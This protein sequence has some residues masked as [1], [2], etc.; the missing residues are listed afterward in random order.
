MENKEHLSATRE[1]CFEKVAEKFKK[2][3]FIS[4][5]TSSFH[6]SLRLKGPK[7]VINQVYSRKIL[8]LA[9]FVILWC[10]NCRSW[11]L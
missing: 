6:G 8:N 1:F 7:P 10:L 2:D 4:N 11:I 5:A 3:Y 9:G